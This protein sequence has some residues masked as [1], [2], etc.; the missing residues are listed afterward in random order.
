MKPR[1]FMQLDIQAESGVRQLVW[2]ERNGKIREGT[3]ISLE[4]DK[5]KWKVMEKY[6][7]IRITELRQDWKVGGLS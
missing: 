6:D 2:V 7:Q 4:G 3:V 1:E 5:R